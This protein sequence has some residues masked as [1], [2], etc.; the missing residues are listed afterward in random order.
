MKAFLCKKKNLQSWVADPP[1]VIDSHTTL[2]RL[3]TAFF[4]YVRA[5]KECWTCGFRHTATLLF[6]LHFPTKHSTLGVEISAIYEHLF[7]RMDLFQQCSRSL[8][9]SR[10]I[11]LMPHSCPIVANEDA[12]KPGFNSNKMH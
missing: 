1:T 10:Q 6:L 7:K 11:W 4:S 8:F 12:L 2:L 9:S 5:L 3:L